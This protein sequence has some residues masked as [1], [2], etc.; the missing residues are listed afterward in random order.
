[1]LDL[2]SIMLL[3]ISLVKLLNFFRKWS[4]RGSESNFFSGLCP[5][6]S[7]TGTLPTRYRPVPVLNPRAES[8]SHYPN[9]ARNF[10]KRQIV[11]TTLFRKEFRESLSCPMKSCDHPEPPFF[12]EVV[13]PA[14]TTRL[15]GQY[16]GVSLVMVGLQFMQ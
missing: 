10:A 3:V 9:F 12:S 15:P 11:N 14:P 2:D 8:K 16:L 4:S 1:M 7:R 13:G 5:L 6:P